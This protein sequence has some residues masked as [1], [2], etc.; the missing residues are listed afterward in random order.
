VTCETCEELFT[1]LNPSS[2]SGLNGAEI[3]LNSSASHA[4]LR[5]LRTRLELIA[6]E[7][8]KLG[9]VYV[10]SNMTGL[11]GEAR[12]LYDGAS[13]VIVNGEVVAQA[14]QFSLLPVEVT[15]A[16][17]DIEQVR[18]FR[19]GYS[20]G[21]QAA[22]QP[23][24][25][26]IECD[27]KL[28]RD[29]DEIY[30]SQSLEV[31]K[32]MALKIL[33]DMEEIHMATSVYLW[34]YLIRSNA[35][36]F[37]LAL[38]GGLDSSSVLLFVYGM[39]KLVLLSINRGETSTLEDLRRVTGEGQAFRPKKPQDIVSRLLH[40]AYMGTT[41][42]SEETESRAS[43]LAEQTGAYHSNIKI[44]DIVKALDNV[45]TAIWGFKARFESEGG[46]SSESLARQN[47][48]AR[49]R[50]VVAYELA[51]LS[52]TAR[53]LPRAGAPLL[54]LGSGNVDENLRGYYTSR[55]PKIV[56]NLQT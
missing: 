13:M 1:P 17:V 31:A 21:V 14:S 52:T 54:V 7:I 30:L 55:C 9:G 37:F 33:G 3:I 20:R 35:A 29:A 28:G 51:Q 22:S 27:L 23:E 11:D 34:N 46:S 26:R 47:V 53:K 39:A 36:G 41:N 45:P 38:S 42:S 25:P 2:F 48:Q 44:D 8:R 49:T 43:R 15:I 18:S 4:E 56:D 24:Y 40:T 12:M 19:S 50:M 16:T 32:P 5:K 10:Y 6:N